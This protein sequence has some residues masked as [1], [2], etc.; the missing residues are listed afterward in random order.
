MIERNDYVVPYY[1]D[2]YRFDKPPWTYWAQVASFRVFGQNAFAARL[3]SAIA[4]ALI[5]VVICAWGARLQLA[6]AGFWAAIIFTLCPVTFL[7]A[8]GAVADMWLVLFMTLAH[9]A[10]YELLRD[11]FGGSWRSVVVRPT[12][13]TAWWWTFYLA[14]AL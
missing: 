13:L 10:G 12:G 11:R 7:W 3:P 9:W 2:R 8:K 5:A 1:N 4:A 14:L 6:R